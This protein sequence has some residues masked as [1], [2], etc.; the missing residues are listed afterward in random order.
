MERTVKAVLIS[1]FNLDTFGAYLAND[2]SA[3]QVEAR[4]APFGQVQ[5]IL[6]DASHEVW[7]DKPDAALVWTQPQVVSPAFH[8]RQEGLPGDLSEILQDVDLFGKAL[9]ELQSRVPVVLVPLWAI[10]RNQTSPGVL[11]LDSRVGMSRAVSAMNERLLTHLDRLDHVIPLDTQGWLAASEPE[12]F[13]PKLWFLAKVPYANDVFITA[14]SEIK[15]TLRGLAGQTRKLVVLDLDNT[16]WGG[17]V[18]ELGW[19]QLKLGGH[20]AVGEAYIDFQRALKALK[21]RGILLAVVSK[22]EEDVALTAIRNHPEMVLKESDFCGWRINWSDKAENIRQLVGDLNLGLESVVF[23]DDSPVE[24]ARIRDAL[25]EILVPDL[26]R[27]PMLYGS[28][29]RRLDCFNAPAVSAEDLLRTDM[30]RTEQKRQKLKSELVSLDQWLMTLATEVHVESVNEANLA[31]SAQLLNKTNQFNL[32]TRRL[33]EQQLSGWS[34]EVQHF[35]WTFRVKDKLG[36][37]GLTGLASLA[38]GEATGEL[39]DFLLSCRVMGR[40]IEDVMMHVILKKAQSLGLKT[41]EAHFVPTAKNKP[42]LRFLEEN[43]T[44]A[45]DTEM[46]FTWSAENVPRLPAG[47]QLHME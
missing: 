27:D 30:Y 12:A 8:R 47:T 16:L 36:D 33:S 45:S 15:S 39:V 28:M 3:P 40:K 21:H 38:A 17:I 2:G 22:N 1:D 24:R 25:P 32:A 43:A 14:A 19:Q 10:A 23:F 44:R 9:A 5:T 31:R 41:V 18:G 20:D 13:N 7:Q 6:L 34:R 35:T 29:L 11:D 42:C 26:P 46:V 4:V 37:S